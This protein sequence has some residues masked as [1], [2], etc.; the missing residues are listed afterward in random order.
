[1]ATAAKDRT[2]R[3]TALDAENTA[4]GNSKIFLT[5]KYLDAI[6]VCVEVDHNLFKLGLLLIIPI[7]FCIVIGSIASHSNPLHYVMFFCSVMLTVVA[8]YLVYLSNYFNP[9]TREN[10]RNYLDMLRET[11]KRVLK[12]GE[13][14]EAWT[15]LKVNYMFA[16]FSMLLLT[17][18]RVLF[19]PIRR[20]K[21]L[22]VLG[23][24]YAD[25]HLVSDDQ[26]W[27]RD[28]DSLLDSTMDWTLWME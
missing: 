15:V 3:D 4:Q 2:A 20:S 7:I 14:L 1:M 9:S 25:I 18:H 17:N 27:D 28:S 5:Q 6:L 21:S 23:V 26:G 8:C 11:L 12:P 19:I 16:A 22:P 13:L 10:S 24:S